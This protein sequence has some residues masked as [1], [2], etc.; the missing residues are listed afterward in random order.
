M[1]KAMESIQRFGGAMFTPVLLLTFPG[2]MVGLST[3]L[4]TQIIVGDI[5]AAGTNWQLFWA[6]IKSGTN[7]VMSQLPMLFMLGLPIGLAKKENARAVLEAF[8]TYMT[9]NY[10]INGFMTGWAPMFGVDFSVEVGGTSGLAE[11]CS[12]KTLDT[13]VIGAL[14]ISGIS[15]YLHNRFFD[16][17]VPDWLGVFRGSSLVCVISFVVMIPVALLFCFVWPIF[18]DFIQ[19]FQ[20]FMKSSGALGVFVYATLEAGLIPTGLHHFI[21]QPFLY[22]AAVV[23]GGLRAYWTEHLSEFATVTE[24]MINVF[25]EAAFS[26]FGMKKVFAPIGISLAFI[27]TAKPEK[28]K[29]TIARMIPVALTA[30]LCGITEPFEF[31]F[32]FAAP[33]LFG[34]HAVL[35][36]LMNAVTFS[37][38]VVGE[39]SSGLL[40]WL[41][42][43]WI[44]LW[45]NQWPMY[46]KQI[47]VGLVFSGIYFVLFHFLIIKFNF[48]TPGREDEDE[49][50]LYT[51]KEYMERKKGGNAGALTE[52]QEKAAAFLV[53][54]GGA[55]NVTT[56]TN[57]ATRLRVS[58]ADLDKVQS[59]AFFKEFGAHGV[60]RNGTALQVIV[61]LAVPNV[62]SAFEDYMKSGVPANAAVSQ[63]AAESEAEEA[64]AA[65]AQA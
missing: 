33:L 60:V 43:N 54:L 17:K 8:V 14:I 12:V 13:G 47:A 61:G 23:N 41:S 35:A 51:K 64:P 58:V 22:D 40:N 36:G 26:L 3:I 15:V 49:I 11:I 59:D 25:P 6:T 53:G 24:P 37:V 21:Y 56:V 44:P 38:G 65:D 39:F 2:I 45:V 31:T 9:F 52:D 16:T 57:C 18:Q 10:F 4:T 28:R 42:L 50:K 7:A 63:L 55:E 48:K 27:T 30:M 19:S 29:A 46:L 34:V 62:R 1:G 20:G 32:L 5:A